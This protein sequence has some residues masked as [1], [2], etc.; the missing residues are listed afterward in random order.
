MKG[1]ESQAVEAHAAPSDSPVRDLTKSANGTLWLATLLFV[2]SGAA[3]LVYQV[4]WQRI[5]ALTTGV[6]V[7]SIAIITAAFMAG[8]GIG[9]HFGGVLS[10]RLGRRNAVIGFAVLEL[11]VGAFAVASV[12]LY[13]D[14]LYARA[15]WLY[16]SLASA[17]VVHFLS[18][19][20]PTVLMGMSLPFLV[21]GLVSHRVTA[22]RTIG[23]L[24]AA[25]ALGA[26]IGAFLTPWVLLRYLGV[27]DAIAVGAT[28]SFLAAAGGFF[29]SR[30]VPRDEAAQR[31][32]SSTP[33]PSDERTQPFR[34]WVALYA[35]SGFMSL[36]LEMVWFRTLDV[37]A[38]GAAFTFGTLLAVYLVGL[39]GGTFAAAGRAATIRRPLAVFLL[40]QV[41]IVL[42]TVVAHGLLVWLPADWPV[43]ASVTEYGKQLYGLQLHDFSFR[44]F[45]AVYIAAP[46]ILF[47]PSTFLMG[48]GF[49]VLQR[50]TQT[51]PVTS[52]RRVGV[53]QA[54]NI[55]GCT[56]GS[57]LTG[58]VLFDL[59]GTAG[60]FRGLTL[61]AA[62]LAVFGLW[63]LRDRRFVVVGGLLVALAGTFP[64]NA[65]FWR[66]LH[67]A[68]PPDDS[69]VAEDASSVTAL[70]PRTPPDAPGY[71]MTINGRRESWLPYGYLHTLIGSVPA[72]IHPAPEEV[73]I[74]GLGSGD[75]AWAAG[76]REETR[77]VVVFEIASSQLQL[78]ADVL[79]KPRLAKLRNF[80][81]DPRFTIV[82]DD[83][84]RRLHA[85]QRKYDMIV[86]DSVDPDLSLSVYIYSVEYF[87]IVTQR[88]KPGGLACVYA[89]TPRIKA[90]LARVFPHTVLIGK[91][92]MVASLNPIEIDMQTWID[93][94]WSRHVTDY[95][96]KPR[97]RWVRDV[98]LKTARPGPK[99]SASDE[100]N[101]DL[102]P[103]D[104]FVRP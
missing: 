34:S 102:E 36:S 46:T 58:L 20:P 87:Q 5:L 35:L 69:F 47:G 13:Y 99:P 67:G 11:A 94:L 76:C 17:T 96:G 24:Y 68:P 43:L 7:H 80:F 18:L 56:I 55:A 42:T 3:A 48:F 66:R 30:R 32:R 83:A 59:I 29:V 92:L 28:G 97:V 98:H 38:K 85:D 63:S 26:G 40:C 62:G 101:R 70:T 44:E 14:L 37:A 64:D 79:H 77:E 22:P 53:L 16:G 50:A 73:A 100:V 104:E 84:R 31:E 60:V 52:G 19:L 25:N 91:D 1:D 9:S 61:L 4:A 82:R 75:T 51:D 33:V 86:A 72:V 57:L 81:S 2:L 54:A 41:G 6:A 15:M 8:L 39:A 90:A 21:R 88:L 10:A 93:R 65:S 49:P 89:R 23:L 74:V 27:S 71:Y 103:L 78:L 45:L 95:L 12:P